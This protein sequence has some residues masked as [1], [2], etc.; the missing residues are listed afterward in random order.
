MLFCAFWTK[1]LRFLDKNLFWWTKNK[2]DQGG[3]AENGCQSVWNSQEETSV[4]S[5]ENCDAC[6][7][8]DWPRMRHIA[9]DHWK[10]MGLWLPLVALVL[11]FGA[12]LVLFFWID[13]FR[14]LAEGEN[15]PTG[16]SFYYRRDC[17]EHTGWRPY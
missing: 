12:G 10:L 13:F 2:P 8:P 17:Q 14:L 9:L 11:G 16:S 7:Y 1:N 6:D 5:F 4:D 3:G 15:R